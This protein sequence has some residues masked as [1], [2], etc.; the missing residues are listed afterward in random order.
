MTDGSTED[1]MPYFT[2]C[3]W[4]WMLW[5]NECISFRGIAVDAHCT[6]GRRWAST[7]HRRHIQS[8]FLF[9]FF[10][11]HLLCSCV[12]HTI[13][14]RRDM[15]VLNCSS[16]SFLLHL[17]F[18][19]QLLWPFMWRYKSKKWDKRTSL[20]ASDSYVDILISPIHFR[21]RRLELTA[22][23]AHKW[24]SVGFYDFASENLH[25]GGRIWYIPLFFQFNCIIENPLFGR[26]MIYFWCAHGL[27]RC[28]L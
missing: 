18:S 26:R 8:T 24:V 6:I 25:L 12:P 22:N 27:K 14:T 20:Y 5:Y 19:A 21:E 23:E 7:M 4:K 10:S 11:L 1:L 17:E 2:W 3:M 13:D 28:L 15:N 9:K 16:A